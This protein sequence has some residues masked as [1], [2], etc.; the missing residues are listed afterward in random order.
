M[1]PKDILN[2]KNLFFY[3]ATWKHRTVF[4]AKF[5][6]AIKYFKRR[7]LV[8]LHLAV[9]NFVLISYLLSASSH[10]PICIIFCTF[11]REIFNFNIF[12]TKYTYYTHKRDGLTLPEL[13]KR[14]ISEL[15]IKRQ[16]CLLGR[17]RNKD[18]PERSHCM[19][20]GINF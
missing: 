5:N 1:Y 10:K 2:L 11:L 17:H 9:L 6:Y 12:S 20:K 16:R 15:G 7:Y 19:F 4:A 8:F 14:M 13:A 3:L 18:I